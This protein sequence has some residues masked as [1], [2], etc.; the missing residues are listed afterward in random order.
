MEKPLVSVII[1]SHNRFDFLINAIE[2]VQNQTYKNVEIIVV[3]DCS[4]EQKYYEFEFEKNVKVINLEKNQR[5]VLGYISAGHVR[6]FGI[7]NS[8][9]KYIAFLDDDD[10]WLPEKLK[11]QIN[12]L[13]NSNNKFSSTEGLIGKGVYNVDS[14]YLKYNSERFF[15]RIAKKH[16]SSLFALNKKF[17]FPDEFTFD[18][19]K[20]HNSIITSSVVVDSELIKFIGG[21]RPI[22]T[23]NDYAPDYDCWLNILR[24][25][26][27]DY[28]N[29]PL[30]YYDESHGHGREW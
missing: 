4:K 16:R 1:P 21:F 19:I 25:T 27:C 9:G 23:K 20:V 8:K 6:N 29:L 26:N 13:E 2:S 18:F 5:D 3:N 14:K 22:P 30:F 11:I 10:I 7:E 17:Y 15:K 12:K 24:L 28:I